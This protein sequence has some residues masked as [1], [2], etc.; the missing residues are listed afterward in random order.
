MITMP[1][2]ISYPTSV[3]IQKLGYFAIHIWLWA[4][5]IIKVSVA[6]TLLRFQNTI[7]WRIF[8][9]P[10]IGVLIA[11]LVG[12]TIFLFN[13]CHPLAGWWDPTTPGAVCVSNLSIVIASDVSSSISITS[14]VLLS[15][16]PIVFL[17][18]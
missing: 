11:H 13:A 6:L 2:S 17:R 1:G 4:M 7:R 8:L 10:I 16:S 15:L 14:D 5:A 3:N 18:K 9:Y 12:N